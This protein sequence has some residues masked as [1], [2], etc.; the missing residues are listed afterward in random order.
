MHENM[1]EKDKQASGHLCSI[2]RERIMNG[3]SERLAREA[4]SKDKYKHI[5]RISTTIC[6]CI[7]FNFQIKF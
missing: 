3:F 7:F 6:G 1:S 5:Y 2:A 4:R